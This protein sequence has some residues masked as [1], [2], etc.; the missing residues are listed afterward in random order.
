M[1]VQ[2][3]RPLIRG[4]LRWD[5]KVGTLALGMW[6]EMRKTITRA[7][8]AAYAALLGDTNPLHLDAAF[9]ATTQF[10]RPIAHGM[11]SAGLIP[12]V[13]G[14]IIPSSVYVSQTLHFRRPVFVG[15]TVI[16]RIR[17]TGVKTTP[18]RGGGGAQ[19]PLVT[20]ETLVLLDDTGK[21]ALE[22]ESVCL[23]PPLLPTVV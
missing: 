20:C 18:V 16:A 15:D 7:D 12:T 5:P 19:Q 6:A 3:F 1:C 2:M 21:T 10:K 4:T 8:V 23:L 17:V 11:L 14:A 13:F 22:G 9:A